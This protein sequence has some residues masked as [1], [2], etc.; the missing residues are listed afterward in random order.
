MRLARRERRRRAVEVEV[1]EAEACAGAR[2]GRGC[3]RRCARRWLWW[4]PSGTRV[5]RVSSS[6]VDRQAGE[7]GDGSAFDSHGEAL[8]SQ[9]PP[10]ALRAGLCWVSDAR[11]SSKPSVSRAGRGSASSGL[12]QTE[13]LF[14]GS[15][16]CRARGPGSPTRRRGE[17]VFGRSGAAR[18]TGRRARSR[19]ARRGRRGSAGWCAG[20]GCQGA[21]APSRMLRSVSRRPSRDPRS[22]DDPG[23]R[24]PDRPP[25]GC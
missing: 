10:V 14:A 1:A 21:R 15:A 18:S 16:R 4:R 24:R 2:F 5:P 19:A 17:G 6:A 3:R 25:G 8:G 23:R 7:I 13:V 22:S 20:R 11:R 9:S 12:T